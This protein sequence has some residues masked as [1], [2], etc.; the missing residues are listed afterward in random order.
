VLDLPRHLV[1]SVATRRAHTRNESFRD[2][3]RCRLI[4]HSLFIREALSQSATERTFRGLATSLGWTEIVEDAFVVMSGTLERS[5]WWI[6]EATLA[7]FMSLF[8][9]AALSWPGP[10]SLFY[11]VVTATTILVATGIVECFI[12]RL[13]KQVSA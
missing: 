5:L 6:L 4:G 3:P 13:E 11:R 9:W 12:I 7:I 1:F 8:A 10:V 2:S